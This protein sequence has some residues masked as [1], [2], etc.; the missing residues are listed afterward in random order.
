VN[1]GLSLL[2]IPPSPSGAA[3]R[4]DLICGLE[5]I[6]NPPDLFI[7][8]GGQNL[9]K[10]LKWASRGRIVSDVLQQESF[11]SLVV[12]SV[13]AL[14]AFHETL[15]LSL[16]RSSLRHGNV[17]DGRGDCFVDLQCASSK[18]APSPIGDYSTP[19][20]IFGRGMG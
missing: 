12:Q 20:S 4:D 3:P 9:P 17:S 10:V 14:V 5:L 7:R 16:S 15:T 13:A 6:S 11:V 8:Q 18:R 19:T 1:S 2:W